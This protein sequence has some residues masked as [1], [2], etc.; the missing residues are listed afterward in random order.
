MEIFRDERGVSTAVKL[1]KFT[2]SVSQN[3]FHADVSYE[4]EVEKRDKGNA[5][6]N[7]EE[8]RVVVLEML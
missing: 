3:G 1:T 5:A 2:R 6:I 7:F 8:C 4:V